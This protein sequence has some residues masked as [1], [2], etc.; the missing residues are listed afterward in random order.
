M[1]SIA[2]CAIATRLTEVNSIDKV[3]AGLGQRPLVL[4]RTHLASLSRGY[5]SIDEYKL[6][7][8]EDVWR[9]SQTAVWIPRPS[10]G[11]VGLFR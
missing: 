6:S 8:E 2:E 4:H 11:E 7:R 5:T 10:E 3:G 9:E 1:S